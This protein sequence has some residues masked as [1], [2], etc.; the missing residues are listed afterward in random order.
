MITIT[1]SSRSSDKINV[2]ARL[3]KRT[4][5]GINVEISFFSFGDDKI[6]DKNVFASDD[7]TSDISK[8]SPK[9]CENVFAYMNLYHPQIHSYL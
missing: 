9:N 1:S 4:S 8:Y 2:K 3:K 7:T 5:C 6:R